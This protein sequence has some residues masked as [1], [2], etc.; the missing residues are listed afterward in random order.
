MW[1]LGKKMVQKNLFAGQKYRH[2]PR[3]WTCGHSWGRGGWDELGVALTYI[4]YHV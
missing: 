2:R 1:N 3:E 4:H